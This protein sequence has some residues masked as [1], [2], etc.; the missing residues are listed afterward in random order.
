MKSLNM[1]SLCL[2]FEEKSIFCKYLAGV[3]LCMEF[4]V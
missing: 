2:S 1:R 4:H 3:W